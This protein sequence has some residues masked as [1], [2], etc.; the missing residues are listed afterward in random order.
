MSDMASREIAYDHHHITYV[1]SCPMQERPMT[2]VRAMLSMER[3]S[4]VRSPAG[5]ITDDR[6]IAPY[7]PHLPNLLHH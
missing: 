4:T 5:S 7:A 6:R 2:V 1:T 3:V